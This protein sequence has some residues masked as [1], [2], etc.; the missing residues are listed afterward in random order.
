MVKRGRLTS[1][2]LLP[3]EASDDIVWALSELNQ[4]KRTQADILFELN[5]RLAVK[6]IDPISTGA[7][8]R[9]STRLAK[10]S[11]QLE[12]RRHLYAG[13]A[14]RF[15]PEEVSK[16]DIVLGE[17]LKTLIDELL[18]GDGLSPKNAMELCRAYKD[19]LAAQKV[20]SERLH[21]MKAE[22][23]KKAIKAIDNLE[24]QMAKTGETPDGQEVIRK[25]RED[26]Y[27]IFEQ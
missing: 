21:Q 1:I 14:E 24:T 26:V 11:M 2:D 22:M 25:I 17:F 6:G 16:N 7:F 18:D 19:T 3:D 10:R 13:M 5:D 4:R 8:S 20:S 12:E 27:G 23:T 9:Q 15:T